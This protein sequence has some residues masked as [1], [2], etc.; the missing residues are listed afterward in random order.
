MNNNV[1]IMLDLSVSAPSIYDITDLI[2][3]DMAI[4]FELLEAG[5]TASFYAIEG[6]SYWAIKPKG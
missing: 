4:A 6:H 2:E 5:A 1:P 3:I